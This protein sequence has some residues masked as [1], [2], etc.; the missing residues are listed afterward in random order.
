ML[1]YEFINTIYRLERGPQMDEKFVQFVSENEK[2]I[3]ELYNDTYKFKRRV[4]SN[5]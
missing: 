4:T 3:N 2:E 5:S 1:L